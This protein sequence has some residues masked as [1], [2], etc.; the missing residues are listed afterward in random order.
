M[1]SNT[2]KQIQ[3]LK[4]NGMIVQTGEIFR[5]IDT[6]Q[7]YYIE[8]RGFDSKDTSVIDLHPSE[9]YELEEKQIKEDK[10][11]DKIRAQIFREDN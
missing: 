11:L 9:W 2:L 4:Q 3:K 7:T 8:D 5:N 6:G 10:H 1:N